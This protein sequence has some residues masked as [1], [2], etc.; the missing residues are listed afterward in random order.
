MSNKIHKLADVQSNKIGKDS[1]IW[2]Y[3]VVLPNARIGKNCNINCHCFVENDV[4][5][6]NNVTL[7]CGVYIW[8]GITIEDEVFI[9]PNVTFIN[10]RTPRSKKHLN[11]TLKTLIKKGA[12]IGANATILGGVTIGEYAMVGAASMVTKDIKTHEL[13]YGNPATH[14]GYVCKCGKKLTKSLYC[15]ECDIDYKKLKK[16]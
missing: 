7:K 3:V 5:I 14:R 8:N 9:G 2:Q 13:W 1:V 16:K 11:S 15:N 12:S 10:D 6:G 4:V